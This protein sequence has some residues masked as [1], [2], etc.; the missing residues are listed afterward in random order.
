MSFGQGMVCGVGSV[1]ILPLL[2]KDTPK[3]SFVFEI[4]PCMLEN[5][6]QI[7]LIWSW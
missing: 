5:S 2:S 4:H 1:A 6:S 7:G 3:F